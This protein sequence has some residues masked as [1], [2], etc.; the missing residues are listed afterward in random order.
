MSLILSQ[1]VFPHNALL[2]ALLVPSDV[3]S[4]SKDEEMTFANHSFVEHLLFSLIIS[5]SHNVS[6]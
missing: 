1:C 6:L 3:S 5:L 4:E 2:E